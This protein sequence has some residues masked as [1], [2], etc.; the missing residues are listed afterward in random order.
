LVEPCPIKAFALNLSDARFTILRP[1][2]LKFDD[3][4]DSPDSMEFFQ[5]AQERE[6]AS[7]P[8]IA[9]LRPWEP[10][11][12]AAIWRVVKTGIRPRYTTG[13]SLPGEAT[14]QQCAFNRHAVEPV[15]GTAELPGRIIA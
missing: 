6:R 9:R 12:S 7:E 13:D 3:D 5:P 15:T 11:R 2:P 4:F 10:R 8:A 1:N 14:S